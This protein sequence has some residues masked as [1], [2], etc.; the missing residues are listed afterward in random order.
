MGVFSFHFKYGKEGSIDGYYFFSYTPPTL[1]LVVVPIEPALV[2]QNS[3]YVN[4]GNEQTGI[5]YGEVQYS[6]VHYSTVQ[7]STVHCTQVWLGSRAFILQ[8]CGEN[9]A[10]W[11]AVNQRRMWSY[12]NQ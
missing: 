7:Y 10:M 4:Y 3:F 6:S 1:L 8:S 11:C 5:V 12:M 9:C 2:H